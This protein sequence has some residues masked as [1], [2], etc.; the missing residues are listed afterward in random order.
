[1]PPLCSTPILAIVGGLGKNQPMKRSKEPLSVTHPELA[2]Q[3]VGW[4]PS[5]VNAP[6]TMKLR[7]KCVEG[8]EWEAVVDHRS[9]RNDGCPFCSGRKTLPGFND[10][11][12]THPDL[13]EMSL[14]WDPTSLT[15]GSNKKVKWRCLIGHEWDAVIASRVTGRGCPVCAGKKIVQGV[16]DLA[17][18][19]PQIASQSVGWDPTKVSSG[20]HKQY[21]WRCQNSH[22]WKTSPK[23]RV[24]GDGCP[25]CSGKQIFKGFNDLATT[26]PK[27]ANEAYKWDPTTSSFGSR[28]K[29]NWICSLG[30]VFQTYINARVRGD[31]CPFC[32]GKQTLEG[33]NDL[34]TTHPRLAKQAF[35]WN[36]QTFSRGSS[37]KMDWKC[38]L[39]H[40]WSASPNARTNDSEGHKGTDC[41]YCSGQTI[42]E[43]FNDLITTNPTLASE[44]FGWDPSKVSSGSMKR[45][46]WQCRNGHI[47][48]SSVNTRSRGHGCPT[49]AQKGFDPNS[50]GWLYFIEHPKWE[51]FQIGITNV[52]DDRLERHKRLGWEV[53]EIRGP[54]D[55]HLTQQ[56]ETA[57]LRMLKATGA[58]LS[59]SKIAGKFDGYS[60]A[61]RQSTFQ[62]K[63]IKELMQLTEEYEES[64]LKIKSSTKHKRVK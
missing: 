37:K 51:M 36:P 11:A 16:N 62:A 40:V 32:S 63:S 53:L 26:H 10:L 54:M 3:A 12:T 56:W 33:F 8:H 44:A 31:G 24:R 42:L 61:W 60:E 28:G 52:P 19:F 38:E 4:D 30:H 15:S 29:K 21:L 41:P 46:K 64:E 55:G 6:S 59:N 2:K 57:I 39:G 17:L 49:C 22:E 58:D 13:A 7:W 14:G 25:F 9:R 35:A 5:L 27:L 45:G 23:L 1:V 50:D 34:A 48:I 43:G 47:W 20:S 18:A